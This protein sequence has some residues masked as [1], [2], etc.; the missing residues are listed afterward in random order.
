M[1]E[2]SSILFSKGFYKPVYL[3]GI[4]GIVFYFY[5]LYFIECFALPINNPCA[6][7]ACI[8]QMRAVI[9]FGPIAS[10]IDHV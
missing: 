10:V 1:D 8:V 3:F 6:L 5:S 9:A 2:V 7:F 4:C